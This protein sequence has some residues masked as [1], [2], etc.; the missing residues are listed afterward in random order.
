MAA[1]GRRVLHVEIEVVAVLRNDG[2]AGVD[3]LLQDVLPVPDQHEVVAGKVAARSDDVFPAFHRLAVFGQDLFHPLGEIA[4]QLLFIGVAELLHQFLAFSAV[5]PRIGGHFL[6]A[7]VEV[8]RGEESRHFL[9][10]VVEHRVVLLPAHAEDVVEFAL[11]AQ[12]IG[13]VVAHHFGVGDS[14]GFG[15]AG[16]VDFGDDFDA[17]VGGVGH[18]F[19]DVVLGIETAIALLAGVEGRFERFAAAAPGTDGRQFRIL[20]DFHAPAVVV[21]QVPVELVDL[22]VGQPVE[23]TQDIIFTEERARDVEHAAAP[24]EAGRI[25]DLDARNLPLP[26][27]L[28][29]R[30][31]GPFVHLR[32]KH[33]QER[34]DGIELAGARGSADQDPVGRD[35][36]GIAFLRET[37]HADERNGPAAGRPAVA[38][39]VEE[40]GEMVFQI[41]HVEGF[42]TLDPHILVK[43]ERGGNRRVGILHRCGHRHEI[44][45]SLGGS[46]G[47]GQAKQSRNHGRQ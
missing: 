29:V 41:L 36:Q 3:G 26:E 37:L 6:H 7:H 43:D 38:H 15:V 4:Q 30:P 16:Q 12:D 8:F 44:E 18:D 25:H 20:L 34:L 17:P 13:V 35:F 24:G 42:S 10:D 21:G 2:E 22:V 1:F 23:V 33:L 40:A 27:Q 19:P 39:R 45:R 32:R 14:Q 28:G 47:G 31:F 9:D 46:D 5:F 11:H